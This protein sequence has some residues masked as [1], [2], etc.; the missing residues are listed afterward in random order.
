VLFHCN[1]SK[2]LSIRAIQCLRKQNDSLSANITPFR[3]Q[4]RPRSTFGLLC[5]TQH[6]LYYSIFSLLIRYTG[7]GAPDMTK[8]ARI[9]RKVWDVSSQTFVG[10]GEVTEGE[11]AKLRASALCLPD[12]REQ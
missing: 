3:R 10:T 11:M 12:D 9:E 6:L 5:W 7:Q 2:F 4:I 8:R 1:T